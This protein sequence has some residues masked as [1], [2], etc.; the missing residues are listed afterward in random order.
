MPIRVTDLD[1]L[2][3][4]VR[5][6]DASLAFYESLLGLE[7]VG[8]EEFAGGVRPFVSVRLGGQLIDL[9]P[10]ATYDADIGARAG[11]LIHFCLRVAGDLDGEVLPLL[12]G[13]GVEILESTPA[14]RFGATG[15]GR[16]IYVRDRDGYIV[17]F[18]E[19][20]PPS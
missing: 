12:R 3:L 2:V 14:V 20:E 8:R 1:H 13:A 16:S 5:D 17:E 7:V 6:L 18:K 9:W 11:G 4:R 19:D 15:Y 10:D